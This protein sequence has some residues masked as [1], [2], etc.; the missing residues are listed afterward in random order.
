MFFTITIS[1][2]KAVM[3]FYLNLSNVFRWFMLLEEELLF[4]LTEEYGE[5]QMSSWH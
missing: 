1:V 3:M 2:G 4:F 5:E